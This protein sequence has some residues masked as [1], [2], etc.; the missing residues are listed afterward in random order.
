M[1]SQAVARQA[2]L[3]WDSPDKNTGVGSIPFS[4]GIFSTQDLTQVSL[5]YYLSHLGSPIQASV[6][7]SKRI[8]GE[9][10]SV[11]PRLWVLICWAL[12]G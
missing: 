1:T 10:E 9:E 5:I 4:R 12:G 6:S 3:L 2:P 11:C 8:M 7:P